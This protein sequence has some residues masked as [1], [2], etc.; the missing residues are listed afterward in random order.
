MVTGNA[1]K[2]APPRSR[3]FE[4]MFTISCCSCFSI[5]INMVCCYSKRN[6]HGT[7]ITYGPAWFFL[8]QASDA[9]DQPIK[10]CCCSECSF[11]GDVSSASTAQQEIFKWKFC[12]MNMAERLNV[13]TISATLKYQSVANCTSRLSNDISL[14][15]H[16]VGT[17]QHR[18][19]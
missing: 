6:N 1:K 4:S 14:A 12:W 18:H 9:V 15:R 11:F 17:C 19:G 8:P 10:I 3:N 2:L 7:L 16:T 13:S 5:A